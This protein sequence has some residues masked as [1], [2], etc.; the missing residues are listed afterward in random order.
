VAQIQD[1]LDTIEDDIFDG[2]GDKHRLFFLM[3]DR[4]TLNFSPYNGMGLYYPQQAA[5]A[6]PMTLENASYRDMDEIVSVPAQ[7]VG[8]T[9]AELQQQFGMSFGGALLPA[10]AAPAPGIVGGLVGT[11][12][13]QSGAIPE[14]FE[15]EDLDFFMEDCDE[16]EDCD[17]DYFDDEDEDWYFDEDCDP[18]FDECEDDWE[19]ED[20]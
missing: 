19:H 20:D 7:Y 15:E 9:N 5:D 18:E 17:D 11:M 16:E 1:G 13:A 2:L 14:F 6:V 4:I 8:I 12:T 10:D 3:L